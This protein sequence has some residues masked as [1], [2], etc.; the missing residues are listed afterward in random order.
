MT[1]AVAPGLIFRITAS[2]SRTWIV[3]YAPGAVRRKAVIGTY[4]SGDR[5]LSLAEARDKAHQIATAA[6]QGR[7][8]PA[9][10]SE[11]ARAAEAR[12]RA[13]KR[14]D[15][16]PQTVE[17]LLRA[18]VA[19][20]C[21]ANRRNWQQTERL[22]EAHVIANIGDKA[23]VT[24]RRAD[25][26]AL[27]EQLRNRKGLGAQVNRIRSQIVAALPSASPTSSVRSSIASAAATPTRRACC[28]VCAKVPTVRP[29]CSAR[30]PRRH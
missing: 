8:L 16:P 7:D 24:L 5:G 14:G 21:Q 23:L 26:V 13:A 12:Q 15:G 29:R 19:N 28:T 11:A 2:A 10:W 9:E 27:L 4:G 18:Y 25:V 6:R 30:R 1:D 20:Y 22:F 17:Q 3:R